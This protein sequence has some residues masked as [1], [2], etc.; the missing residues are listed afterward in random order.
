MRK[1]EHKYPEELIVLGIHSAKFKTEGEL[2]QA[3]QTGSA[4][5][6]EAFDKKV[7]AIVLGIPY[8]ERY[9]SFNMGDTVPYV[10]ENAPCRVIV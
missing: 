7:D 2:V 9:G 6:R 5:V 4:V 10:L 8:R 3:S 1:L